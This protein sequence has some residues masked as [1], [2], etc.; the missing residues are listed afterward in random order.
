MH[1]NR[2]L[3]PNAKFIS[4][5]MKQNEY[6]DEEILEKTNNKCYT[7]TESNNAVNE[8]NI[9]K[10]NIYMHLNIS[11]LLLHHLELYNLI[12]DSKIKPKN[13]WGFQR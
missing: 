4:S 12:S 5:V 7:P 1:G 3:S 9:R 11:S 13:N 2:I 10:Q 6:F 8:T